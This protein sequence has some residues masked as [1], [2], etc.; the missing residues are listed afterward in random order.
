MK[1]KLESTLAVITALA[2]FLSWAFGDVFNS[3]DKEYYIT[4]KAFIVFLVLTSSALISLGVYIFVQKRKIQEL[5]RKIDDLTCLTPF[6]NYD[7][8]CDSQGNKYCPYHK[9]TV[10]H[11]GPSGYEED[12]FWCPTCERWFE[13]KNAQSG[14]EDYPW[15]I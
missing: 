14:S 5:S 6:E 8:L 1:H 3:W 12:S 15:H 9:T 10:T 2:T 4:I 7:V 11:S 13:N